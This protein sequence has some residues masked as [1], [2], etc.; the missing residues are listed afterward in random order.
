MLRFGVVCALLCAACYRP[1]HERVCQV[2]CVFGDPDRAVCPGSLTCGENNLCF[3]DQECAAPV[4]AGDDD[5]SDAFVPP[6]CLNTTLSGNYCPIA[7]H[8]GTFTLR[9]APVLDTDGADCDEVTPLRG[10]MVCVIAADNIAIADDVIPAGSRPL[11]LLARDSITVSG[12]L[13]LSNGG[14]GSGGACAATINGTNGATNTVSASGGPGGSQSGVGGKGGAQNGLQPIA[15][16]VNTGIDKLRGGCPGGT[17]GNSGGAGGAGGGSVEMAA[18]RV[19]SVTGTIYAYGASGHGAAA[20]AGQTA[21]GGG[22]GSG[23]LVLLEAPTLN[24]GPTGVILAHGGA[25][26]GGALSG[27]ASNGAEANIANGSA[28][29]GGMAVGTT[30]GAGG[31]GSGNGAA[32]MPGKNATA[33]NASG[34]GGGGGPGAIRIFS[35]VLTQMPGSSIHPTPS[36]NPLPQ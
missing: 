6:D 28:A 8:P 30:S 14:A 23:G 17:G 18:G 5:A 21:G 33:A 19:I 16:N 36:L 2:A 4:D 13:D 7:F 1:A 35:S 31:N 27:N 34:G 22:G 11:L 29:L 25:G 10:L 9:G 24:V 26:G 3:D 20:T 12:T 15:S 32:A